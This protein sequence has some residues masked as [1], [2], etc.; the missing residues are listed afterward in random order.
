MHGIVLYIV[1]RI[2]YFGQT[3]LTTLSPKPSHIYFIKQTLH[4]GQDFKKGSQYR[5]TVVEKICSRAVELF[6]LN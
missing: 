4:F 2:Q 5:K 6:N 1:A 3:L